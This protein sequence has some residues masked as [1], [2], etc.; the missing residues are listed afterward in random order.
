LGNSW[1]NIIAK[2]FKL[3]FCFVFKHIILEDMFIADYRTFYLC[4]FK[5]TVLF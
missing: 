3:E 5:K 1:E 4:L 2:K